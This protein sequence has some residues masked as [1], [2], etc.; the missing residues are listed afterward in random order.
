LR[1]GSG[2]D[3]AV[4][5]GSYK[6][7]TKTRPTVSSTEEMMQIDE[8]E[9]EWA[10]GI[11]RYLKTGELPSTKE[12]AREVIRHLARY[13]LIGEILYRRG[14]SFPLLK[15]L[16]KKDANYVLGEIHEGVCGNHSGAKT[17]VNKVIKTGYYWPTM[18]KDAT[19]L[20]R[21]CDACQRFARITKSPPEYLH[22]IT[23]P[24]PFAKWG[25]D[26]VGLMP[27]GKGNKKFVVVAVDY[28]TKWAEAEALAAIT[29]DNVIKF[30]WKSIVCRFGIPY[31]MVTDNGKQFDC[32][33]FRKWC[34]ELG[35]RNSYSTPV[36]P[37]SNGQVEV[38]NKTLIQSEEE[39][40]PNE[41]SLGGVPPGGTLVL[42]DHG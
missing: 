24:W 33:R 32:A 7:L 34:F 12:E 20:V 25:V 39:D 3:P 35:I 15:C 42:Q 14:Y 11:I 40:W 18:N 22:S 31:A 5:V 8:M 30:L 21:T 13:T 36:F 4:L 29:T 16:S 17:L 26:I 19:K 41:R 6:I 28:F 37:Q 27:S 23:S 38:T 9:L 10:T 1:I 2:I